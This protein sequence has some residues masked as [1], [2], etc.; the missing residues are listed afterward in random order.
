MA[1]QQYGWVTG[2]VSTGGDE[3]SGGHAPHYARGTDVDS[4]LLRL[5]G[6]SH[7][8]ASAALRQFATV[9]EA[10]AIFKHLW[11]QTP[12]LEDTPA[13]RPDESV[14]AALAALRR[15]IGAS[16]NRVTAQLFI[17]SDLPICSNVVLLT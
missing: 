8:L 12:S 17:A 11:E 4:R 9:V 15:A 2:A 7:A 1:V 10:A 13:R 3:A 6:S 14:F 5:S 16:C